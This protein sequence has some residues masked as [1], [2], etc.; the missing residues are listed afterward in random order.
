[1]FVNFTDTEGRETWVNPL[2]VKLVRTY[3]GLL[4]GKKGTEIWFSFHS[5]SEAVYVPQPPA[6]VAALLDAAMPPV[7]LMQTDD[8]SGGD[9]PG[10]GTIPP[11]G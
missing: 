2:H 1:M 7:V 9:L 10:A 6:D 3:Q 5:T 11:V 8:E 4:G